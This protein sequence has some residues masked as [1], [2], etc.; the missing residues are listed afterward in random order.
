MPAAAR[1]A[2]RAARTLHAIAG[3][4]RAAI[5]AAGAPATGPRPPR[6]RPPGRS[7]AHCTTPIARALHHTA[8]TAHA[9]C[10]LHRGS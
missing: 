9:R 1:R 10:P 8:R 3:G 2:G 7:P 4:T 6:R 5:G